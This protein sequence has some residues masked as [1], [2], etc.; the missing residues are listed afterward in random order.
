MHLLARPASALPSVTK[1]DLEQAWEA[2][3]KV[4]APAPPARKFR[5]G[6]APPVDLWV[7]DKDAAASSE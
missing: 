3:R 6:T 2:A 7:Q 5:F 1:R 4:D